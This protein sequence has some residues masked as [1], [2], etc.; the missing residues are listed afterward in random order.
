MNN[1]LK[2]IA[3]LDALATILEKEGFPLT[4]K[5]IKDFLNQYREML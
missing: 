2:R 3:K 1:K 4:A 5:V